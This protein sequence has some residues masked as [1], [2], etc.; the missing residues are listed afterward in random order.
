MRFIPRAC[1]LAALLLA[2]PSC[3]QQPNDVQYE[4]VE[5]DGRPL[6]SPD[7]TK[8]FPAVAGFLVV[9]GDGTYSLGFTIR[10]TD[11]AYVVIPSS[12]LTATAGGQLAFRP[13]PVVSHDWEGDV[14]R[15]PGPDGVLRMND[16]SMWRRVDSAP[17]QDGVYEATRVNGLAFPATWKG[18]RT[19]W[20][21]ETLVV[22]GGR[23]QRTTRWRREGRADSAAGSGTLE[24]KGQH[25]RFGSGHAFAAGGASTVSWVRRPD[26]ALRLMY[27]DGETWDYRRVPRSGPLPRIELPERREHV[28]ARG[29]RDIRPGQALDGEITAEDYEKDAQRADYFLLTAPQT[30]PVT[31]IVSADSIGS[32]DAEPVFWEDGRVMR[33]GARY[34]DAAGRPERRFAVELRGSDRMYLQVSA[35]AG[36]APVR[37]RIRVVQGIE[38]G[39]REPVDPSDPRD[40]SGVGTAGGVEQDESVPPR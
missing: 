28:A 39:K 19:E 36:E 1:A 31:V 37:Y 30:R 4:L 8:R 23:F 38:E 10:D 35:R 25:A 24:V 6:S 9:R 15:V 2:A 7:P 26:G 21:G 22:S 16:G 3:A 14:V 40:V 17:W 13:E 18:G 34:V 11:S 32:L 12:G 5:W 20:L 27:S 33:G 29:V